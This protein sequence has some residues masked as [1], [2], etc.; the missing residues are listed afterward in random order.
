M[1]VVVCLCS[2]L[3]FIVFVRANV[4]CDRVIRYMYVKVLLSCCVSVV[5]LQW[6]TYVFVLVLCVCCVISILVY[7]SCIVPL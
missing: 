4:L 6:F 3:C 7:C 5:L 1:C 2:Y